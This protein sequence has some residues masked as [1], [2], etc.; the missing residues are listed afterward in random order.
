MRQH[1]NKTCKSLKSLEG[2]NLINIEEVD[3]IIERVWV[4]LRD[5]ITVGKVK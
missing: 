1:V 3:T 4:R 2:D 5:M